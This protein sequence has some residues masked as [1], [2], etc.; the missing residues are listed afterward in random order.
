MPNNT[1]VSMLGASNQKESL[2]AV[3]GDIENVPSKILCPRNARG[4]QSEIIPFTEENISKMSGLIDL[5]GII[6]RA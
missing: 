5:L 2:K 1:A 6:P 4:Q 3:C